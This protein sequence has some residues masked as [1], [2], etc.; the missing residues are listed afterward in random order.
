MKHPRGEADASRTASPVA[1]PTPHSDHM[2]PARKAELLEQ[3]RSAEERY[4]ALF[5]NASDALFVISLEGGL[6]DVNSRG[7]ELLQVTAQDFIGHHI[8]EFASP[9]DIQ[10]NLAEF[11]RLVSL[12]SAQTAAVPLVRGDGTSLLVE[13][14]GKTIDI[15]GNHVLLAIGRDVTERV[16][17]AEVLAAAEERYRRLV[18]RLP[19]AIWIMEDG[20]RMSFITAN[21]EAVCGTPADAMIGRSLSDILEFIHPDDREQVASAVHALFDDGQ[22]FDIEYRRRRVDGTWLWLRNRSM[23]LETRGGTR[24]AEGLLT[25]VT[26]QHRLEEELI[27][28]QKMEAVGQL[29]GGIAHDFNNILAAILAYGQFLLDDLVDGDPRRADAAEIMASAQR[30]ASLTRQLLAFSRRQVLDPTI[31][32]LNTVVGG[33]EKMLRRLIGED[34][35]MSI[36]R[37]PGLGAVRA[38]VGQIEQVVMNMVVNARDAMPR[39]GEL[40]IGTA[41]VDVSGFGA[42]PGAPPP[43]PYVAVTIRDSGCGMT[44]EVQAH[45][46]EP[47]FTTKAMDR[48]TGLGLSTCH[49]IVRQS[50][51]TIVVESQPGKGTTFT[52]YLP[53]VRG[54]AER[55]R[56]RRPTLS[57]RGSETVLLVEDDDRVRSAVRRILASRGYHVLA[58]NGEQQALA[59]ARS[60]HRPIHLVLSDVVMPSASGFDLVVQL[61]RE[62]PGLLALFMSGYT[63]HP[64]LGA[65]DSLGKQTHFLQKPFVPE[66]LARKVREVLDL[67]P[68]QA[69]SPGQEGAAQ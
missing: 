39:G 36:I 44:P 41:D 8:S 10:A 60:H 42:E 37:G 25:N 12:E 30:A 16:R 46:F 40:V 35:S 28:A 26:R 5:E 2:H 14:T 4:R 11:Q 9:G 6:L 47:F 67:G 66:A 34:V 24:V 65:V 57:T 64:A 7:L 17:A 69:L 63:D 62:R 45:I 50:G 49:G 43:G 31:V 20:G 18:E 58:A 1:S 56:Q 32:D 33:L 3:V 38:D 19:D 53:R 55:V 52:I 15:A 61:R 54:Q 68:A 51:G 27:Q 48:G 21:A 59:A 22:P 29:T 23:G 13:F